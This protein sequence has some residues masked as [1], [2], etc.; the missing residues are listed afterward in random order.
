MRAVDTFVNDLAS[1][2]KALRRAGLRY[3]KADM[4]NLAERVRAATHAAD[5][6]TPLIGGHGPRLASPLALMGAQR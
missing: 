4:E 2:P 3:S 1:N 5:S 6:E